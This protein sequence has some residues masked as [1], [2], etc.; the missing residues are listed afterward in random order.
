LRLGVSAV[1]ESEKGGGIE[2]LMVT[3]GGQHRWWLAEGCVGV[4]GCMVGSAVV[5]KGGVEQR[6]WEVTEG[7]VA[8]CYE[9]GQTMK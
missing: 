2:G 1:L 9:V 4:T 6:W 8:N 5:S 3:G 7:G